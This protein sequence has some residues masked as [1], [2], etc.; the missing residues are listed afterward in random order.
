MKAKRFKP[1][2]ANHD[3]E[4][5]Y[6]STS[7]ACGRQCIPITLKNEIQPSAQ[8]PQENTVLEKLDNTESWLLDD[9]TEHPSHH[10]FGKLDAHSTNNHPAHIEN[11]N[12]PQNVIMQSPDSILIKNGLT[13]YAVQVKIRTMK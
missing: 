1:P 2:T 4:K 12:M 6:K 11:Q 3:S 7:P 5:I 9:R 10:A 13:K 8:L